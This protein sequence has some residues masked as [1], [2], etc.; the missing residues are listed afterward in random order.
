MA[1]GEQRW[2]EIAERV[3]N[4]AGFD[5]EDFSVVNAGRRRMVRVIIDADDG[6]DL[7]QAATVSRRL[8][9]AFDADEEHQSGAP[10]GS[11]AYTLE[12]TSPGIGR[13]LTEPRHFHRARGRLVTLNRTDGSSLSARVVGIDADGVDL[14]GGKS[15]TDPVTVPFADIAKARVEVD[16]SGPSAAVLAALAADPRSADVAAKAGGDPVSIDAGDDAD[17][18]AAGDPAAEDAADSGDADAEH[19]DSADQ[20]RDAAESAPAEGENR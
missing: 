19:P 15:G 6:V 3:A 4:E 1:T 12:V 2:R 7:D 8:S 13:P 11:Q 10:V 16:F 18:A 5:L 14:L 17:A 20:A 9:A